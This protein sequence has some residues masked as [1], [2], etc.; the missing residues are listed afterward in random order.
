MAQIQTTRNNES[1]RSWVLEIKSIS[2]SCLKKLPQNLFFALE[3]NSKILFL[4]DSGCEISVL[5][6]LLSNG[7]DQYFKPQS[8]TIQGIGNSTIH[9]TGSVEKT[10]N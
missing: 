6:K 3:K 7:V 1:L 8:K 2:Q 4:I 5:P 9:P 10:L